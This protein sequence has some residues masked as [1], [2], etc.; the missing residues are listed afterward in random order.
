MKAQ[1]RV[2]HS[3]TEFSLTCDRNRVDVGVQYTRDSRCIVIDLPSRKHIA[4]LPEQPRSISPLSERFMT[5]N[6]RD[7]MRNDIGD[8]PVGITDHC[9]LAK[10][11]TGGEDGALVLGLVFVYEDP[12]RDAAI[13]RERRR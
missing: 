2:R 3:Q 6:T 5:I 12:W 11:L 1:S 9:V 8:I 4:Q 10:R 7:P 13:A